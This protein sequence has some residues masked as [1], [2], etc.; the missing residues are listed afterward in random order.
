METD[1]ETHRQSLGGAQTCGKVGGRIEASKQNR[2]S[3]GRP[4]K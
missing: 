3:M 2:D 1:A 4:T